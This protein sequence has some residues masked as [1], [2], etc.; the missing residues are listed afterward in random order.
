MWLEYHLII[1]RGLLRYMFP[2][3]MFS[4]SFIWF[5]HLKWNFI[6]ICS[7]NSQSEECWAQW[8]SFQVRL[9]FPI[10]ITKQRVG[11]CFKT[12]N[13]QAGFLMLKRVTISYLYNQVI[14]AIRKSYIF[15]SLISLFYFFHSIIKNR[16]RINLTFFF[17]ISK[18]FICCTSN[19]FFS[20]LFLSSVF[21][22]EIESNIFNFSFKWQVDATYFF[23][24][25]LLSTKCPL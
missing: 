18:H 8:F 6:S 12:L 23:R 16:I 19:L 24:T 10:Y 20:V 5:V 2:T 3:Y 21:F 11:Q 15:P 17:L 13:H 14:K 4:L 25:G 7:K 22:V 9:F 1:F